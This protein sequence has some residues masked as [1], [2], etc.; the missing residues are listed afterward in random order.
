MQK[1]FLTFVVSAA[2][3]VA[4]TGAQAETPRGKVVGVSDGDTVTLLGPGWT[5][6]KI[7]LA[8]IDASERG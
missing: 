4:G 6:H 2:L 7:R 5:E 8:H 3:L 1:A